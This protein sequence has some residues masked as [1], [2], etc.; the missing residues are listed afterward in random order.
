MGTLGF[1]PRTS[2]LSAVR[3]N[4]AEPRALIKIIY[5][6]L[7]ATITILYCLNIYTL[8]FSYFKNKKILKNKKSIYS[9]L[10]TISLMVSAII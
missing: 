3:A 7:Q 8:C 1:E 4:Q 6:T 2:R 9:S 10:L 5:V